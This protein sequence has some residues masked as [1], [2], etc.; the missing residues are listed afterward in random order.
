[1]KDRKIILYYLI[2]TFIAMGTACGL[3][4]LLKSFGII[5]QGTIIGLILLAIGGLSSAVS[6]AVV[7]ERSGRISTYRTLIK[8]FFN[9]K[10]PLKYCLLILSFL[11]ISFGVYFIT[12]N[13]SAEVKWYSFFML[14]AVS[15]LFGGVEEIGWRYTFQPTLGKYIPFEVASVTTFFCWGIWHVMYFVIDGSIGNIN[16]IPFL[17]GLISSCFI[18]GAIYQLS[19]SLCLCVICHSLLN[20]FSQTVINDGNLTKNIIIAII[21]ISLAIMVV[22]ITKTRAKR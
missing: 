22:R 3:T 14:F 12:G 2:G 15:I 20:A 21:N 1:M 13:I 10:Q 5:T 7:S 6:G 19:Q 9:L 8:D 17:I 16:F 11:I 4:L 18:M